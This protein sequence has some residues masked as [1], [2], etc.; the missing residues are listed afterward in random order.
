MLWLRISGRAR[1]TVASAASSP[2]KSGI[3]TSML[4]F[5]IR[6]RICRI[7]P[8]KMADPPFSSSSRLRSGEAGG[9]AILEFVA[10]DRGNDGVMQAHPLDRL[11]HANRL[12]EV[13]HAWPPRLDGA[14]CAR[15]G[16]GIAP[17][18]QTRS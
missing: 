13:E 9:P 18:H 10:V 5:G 16:A 12:A 11:G 8:A 3:R 17:D 6:L 15:A 4:H 14:E 7:V 2:M 1:I